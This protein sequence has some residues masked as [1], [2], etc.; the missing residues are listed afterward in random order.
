LVV[1]SSL[2]L[3]AP[4][5]ARADDK[6][7]CVQAF[8][9]GQKLR[10]D[11]KARQALEAFLEC[12]NERCPAMVR[13][14]CS[15]A[16]ERLSKAAASVVVVVRDAKGAD[17]PNAV[18][19]VDG[20]A[21]DVHTGRAVSIDPGPRH[22]RVDVTGFEPV[23]QEIVIHEAEKSRLLTF[24]V[25]AKPA[26]TPPPPPIVHHDDTPRQ[27]HTALPWIVAGV[28]AAVAVTGAVLFVVGNGKVS[29]AEAL[30]PDQLC[31]TSDALSR[32]QATHDD[33][34]TLKTAGVIA[35][36]LGASLAAA[37]L[38]WHFVEPTVGPGQAGVRLRIRF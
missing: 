12:Q 21:I 33:G 18:V 25:G 22:F 27:T 8:E 3:A 34:A 29:D 5:V 32:A 30:C 10:D 14:D 11:G 13:R 37:G 23:E 31:Q 20:I 2:V 9:L 4:G 16:V 38:V 28:G 1:L 35:L 36:G 17:V 15:E 7:A 19:S 6:L 26:A 24:T